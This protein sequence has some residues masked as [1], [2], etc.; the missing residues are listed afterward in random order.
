M[1]IETKTKRKELLSNDMED[2]VRN[3]QMPELLKQS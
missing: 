1:Q 2:S 3:F